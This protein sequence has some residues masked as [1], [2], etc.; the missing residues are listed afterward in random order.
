MNS[1][2]RGG[3]WMQRGIHG[4]HVEETQETHMPLKRGQRVRISNVK[5]I[6]NKGY[7][8]NW[9]K[10]EFYI[11]DVR[12]PDPRKENFRPRFVYKLKD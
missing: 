1:S 6:F 5:E 10:E 12:A 4:R 7:V 2:Q 9:T 11:S 3:H 8:P